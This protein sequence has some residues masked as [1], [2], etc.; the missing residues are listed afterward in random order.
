MLYRISKLEG[1]SILTLWV[2]LSPCRN[3]RLTASEKPLMWICISLASD[4]QPLANFSLC[5]HCEQFYTCS[6]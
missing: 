3:E 6:V 2:N 5:R 4:L 1:Q